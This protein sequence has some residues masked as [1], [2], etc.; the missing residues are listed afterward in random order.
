[1][2][3]ITGLVRPTTVTLDSGSR[4]KIQVC[5]V[6]L[7]TPLLADTMSVLLP[8]CHPPDLVLMY[9]VMFP[10]PGS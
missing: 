9:N 2:L 6:A 3:P 4:T 10:L 5:F 7:K 8:V 1:M